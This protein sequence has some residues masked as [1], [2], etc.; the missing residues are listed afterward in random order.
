VRVSLTAGPHTI[1]IQNREDGAKLDQFMLT[2]T[3]AIP[4]RAEKETKQ[5]IISSE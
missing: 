1:R 3:K 5:Y 2:T 4:V